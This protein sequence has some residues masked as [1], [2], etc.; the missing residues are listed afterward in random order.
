MWIWT[1]LLRRK[2]P[3]LWYWMLLQ[4]QLYLNDAMDTV[5]SED[6]GLNYESNNDHVGLDIVA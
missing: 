6:Y 2:L 3:F 5:P 4:W 1:L